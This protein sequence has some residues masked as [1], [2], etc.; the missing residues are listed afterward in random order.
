M[1]WIIDLEHEGISNFDAVDRVKNVLAVNIN[2]GQVT[3]FMLKMVSL[4]KGLRV[5]FFH[6]LSSAIAVVSSSLSYLFEI[7]RVV[8]SFNT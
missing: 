7:W 4:V 8:R 1:L 6:Q 2:G 3:A 5:A